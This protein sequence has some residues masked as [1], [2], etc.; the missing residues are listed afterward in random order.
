MKEIFSDYDFDDWI[1]IFPAFMRLKR[2][3]NH[4][5]NRRHKAMETA[6]RD[7][8]FMISDNKKTNKGVYET[9]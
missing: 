2:R 7:N 8:E 4:R 6:Q 1:F 3:I 5:D 9:N